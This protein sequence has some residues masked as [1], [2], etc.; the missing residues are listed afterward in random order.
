MDDISRAVGLGSGSVSAWRAQAFKDF[1]RKFASLF[2][3]NIV[4]L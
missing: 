1:C 3:F 4:G 2:N